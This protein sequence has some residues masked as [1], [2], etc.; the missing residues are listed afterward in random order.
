MSL[1]VGKLRLMEHLFEV[2]SQSSKNA[3]VIIKGFINPFNTEKVFMQLK[4]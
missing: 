3:T 2:K 1:L 4:I